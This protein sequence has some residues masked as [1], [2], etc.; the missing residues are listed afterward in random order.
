MTVNDDFDDEY[1]KALLVN[2]INAW[3][4]NVHNL[5]YFIKRDQDFQLNIQKQF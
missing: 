1:Q 5:K 3:D 4:G 2:G